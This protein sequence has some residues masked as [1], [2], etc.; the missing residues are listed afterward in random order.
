MN[1]YQAWLRLL[2]LLLLAMPVPRPAQ[3]QEPIRIVSERL[4]NQFPEALYFHIEVEGQSQITK[5]TLFHELRGT[6]SPTI[7][8]LE[9]DP[10]L[11]VQ[12]SH[13]WHTQNIIVPPGVP[14][15]YHWEIEDED[16]NKLVTEQATFPYDDIRFSWN[17]LEDDE[18]AVLWY[19]GDEEWGQEIYDVVSDSLQQL[20]EKLAAHLEFPIRVVVYG[21]EID[22]RSAFPPLRE[23]IG[24]MAFT[25]NGVTVQIIGEGNESYLVGVIPHE[26]SHLLTHQLTDSPFSTL[27]AWLDEGLAVYNE[28]YGQSYY[29]AIVE[30]AATAGELLPLAFIVGNFPR[31][32][33]RVYL[34]YGQSYC[35]VKYLI[36][37]YGGE[38]LGQ[39]LRM[40]REARSGF[41]EEAAFA[42]LYGLP[43]LD[44]VNAWR[45][46]LGAEPEVAP[47]PMPTM[48]PFPTPPPPGWRATQSAMPMETAT[49]TPPPAQPTAVPTP[50]PSPEPTSAP[51]GGG[52]PGW[53]YRLVGGG[54]VLV[55]A[56]AVALVVLLR[57]K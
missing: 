41:D 55:L 12:A 36:D 51:A 11:H 4:D 30:Q 17:V 24:G 25:E 43:F 39:Y 31:D 23:N 22:F 46:S 45:V 10:A 20:E 9:F 1:R 50:E 28:W 16:G 27:P 49:P 57:R 37:E 52:T 7:A 34:A 18:V 48:V 5:I 6:D 26:I 3:A 38:K 21:N 29:E 32:D 14:V 40:F 47:T 42:E 33:E 54:I 8:P 56:L 19:D 2:V 15:L 13:R 44:F 35:L 53:V